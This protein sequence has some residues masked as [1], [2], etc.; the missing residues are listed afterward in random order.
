MDGDEWEWIV[1]GGSRR[2]RE[3]VVQLLLGVG[4]G[5]R[6]RMSTTSP[7]PPTSGTTAPA[8]SHSSLNY[9]VILTV[10]GL[11]VHCVYSTVY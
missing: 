7:S 11:T 9:K 2:R 8:R 4:G 10:L 3:M 5:W 1:V 6:G